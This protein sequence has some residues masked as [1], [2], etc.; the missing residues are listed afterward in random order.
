MTLTSKPVDSLAVATENLA[1]ST[2]I[3][4]FIYGYPLKE[5]YRTRYEWHY[6]KSSKNY[7]GPVNKIHHNT[8][9]ATHKDTWVVTPQYSS[10]Y[11]SCFADLSNEPLILHVPEI[12]DRYY[13]VQ[14][15]DFYTNS[16]AYIGSRKGDITG[17][18]YLL[19]G[20]SWRGAPPEGIAKV[21]KSPTPVICLLIRVLVKD[22]NEEET[23]KLQ[24]QFELTPLSVWTGE[25]EEGIPAP[26]PPPYHFESPVD[27]FETVNTAVN[28]NPPPADDAGVLSL[29]SMIGIDL[30][31]KF[32]N[33][34]LNPAVVK[35]LTRAYEDSMVIL[36]EQSK[37]LGKFINGWLMPPTEIGNYGNNYLLRMDVA[38]AGLFAND[39]AE[40]YYNIVFTEPDGTPL[41]GTHKFVLHFE[42]D[43]IPPVYPEGFW[44][45][46]MYTH[47]QGY[48][49][50]SAIN[51]YAIGS[52]LK[53]LKYN[54]DGSL[55]L[56][57]QRNSPGKDKE[58][59]WLPTPE[60]LF[61]MVTRLYIPKATV[62]NGSWTPP[63][64]KRV[65]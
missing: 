58:S 26:T 29:L 63:P 3:Q 21:I 1:Y 54:D 40:A 28:E 52:E 17:G 38:Y 12:K 44:S 50:E 49:T 20:P 5:A 46:A 19:A 62:L 32:E 2:G 15:M 10:L 18:D 60:G 24:T 42:K 7:K 8:H 39:S 11:S 51:R 30:N 48:F 16:F 53:G 61:R 43:Q 9:R 64:V 47:P 59:N 27:F 41:N 4:A 14:I 22:N 55:T 25:S 37:T 33:E 6:D 34:N 23:I 57:L 65:E 13:T 31:K 45:V 56:Y 36:D 35:G